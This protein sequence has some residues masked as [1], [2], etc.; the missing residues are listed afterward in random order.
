MGIMKDKNGR[1]REWLYEFQHGHPFLLAE[2][3]DIIVETRLNDKV[4][5]WMDDKQ[6]QKLIKRRVSA[7]YKKR[8]PNAKRWSL[9]STNHPA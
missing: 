1:F 9:P 6:I 5:K 2:E 7:M 8:F 4:S 3:A